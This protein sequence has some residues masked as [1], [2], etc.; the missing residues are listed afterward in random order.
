MK[1]GIQLIAIERQEQIEKHGR[2]VDHDFIANSDGQLRE[3]AVTMASM[4][5]TDKGTFLAPE[6]WDEESFKRMYYS[7]CYVD[8]L[9]VAGAFIAAEIDRINYELK[10]NTDIL[11][12]L[13]PST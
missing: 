10:I 13:N 11:A 12:S 6:G 5:H 7:K 2:T 4:E 8:K 3:A 9:I 1:S